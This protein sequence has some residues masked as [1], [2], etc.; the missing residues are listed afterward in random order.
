[1]TRVGSVSA[2]NV[3]SK[4]RVN[5]QSSA[6]SKLDA[7]SVCRNISPLRAFFVLAQAILDNSRSPYAQ[8]LA[9]ASLIKLVTDHQLT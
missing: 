3:H 5:E 7:A 2:E 4:T 1:M 9:S 8:L 6:A